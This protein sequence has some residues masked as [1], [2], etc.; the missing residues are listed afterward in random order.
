MRD[1][2]IASHPAAVHAALMRTLLCSMLK[3]VPSM[4]AVLGVC[5]LDA[6]CSWNHSCTEI[7]CGDQ[8]S[9]VMHESDWSYSSLTLDVTFDGRTVR[10]TSEMMGSGSCNDPSVTVGA[11]QLADCVETRTKDAVS[12]SCTPNG[13]FQH[14]IF[15]QATPRRVAITVTRPDGSNEHRE[16]ELEYEI[17]RPNG[18]DCDPAC[19]NASVEW[20]L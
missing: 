19:K 14:G 2:S 13:K 18:P 17:H 1:S 20:E 5:G 7:G 9:I 16:I 4:S 6:G 8:A 3:C 10:C 11:E 12:E 15:I